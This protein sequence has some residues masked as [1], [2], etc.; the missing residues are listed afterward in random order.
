MHDRRYSYPKPRP[1]LTVEQV[2]DSSRGCYH[3]ARFRVTSKF[4]LTRDKLM[5]L[6]DLGVLGVGQETSISG[7]C[8][9]SEAPALI[10]M[11]ECIAYEADGS[12]VPGPA[13]NPYSGKPYPPTPYDYYIYEAETRCDSGD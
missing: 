11:S 5:A 3:V 12:A 7:T 1:D 4:R 10:V 8:D 6:R 13:L 9:G 2:Y